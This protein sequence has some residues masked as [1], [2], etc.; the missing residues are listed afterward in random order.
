MTMRQRAA[1]IALAAPYVARRPAA[2]LAIRRPPVPT[3][4][5]CAEQE[6]PQWRRQGLFY[7]TPRAPKDVPLVVDLFI[8]GSEMELLEARMYELQESV[9]WFVVG[10]SRETHRGDTVPFGWLQHA[11]DN[12]GRFAEH[13]DRML[14]VDVTACQQASPETRATNRPD[15]PAPKEANFDTQ[16][17]QRQCLWKLGVPA[18]R[19]R[20]G[21][22]ELPG[23]T[24]FVFTDLDEI[25]DRALV[26]HLKRCATKDGILPAHLHMR[27]QG[28][29][30]RVPCSDGIRSYTGRAEIARWDGIRSSGGTLH[31]FGDG[32]SQQKRKRNI[33]QAGVHMTWFGS[34]AMVD[35]KG[36]THAEGGYWPPLWWSSSGVDTVSGYCG[37]NTSTS[38]AR[39]AGL[40]ARPRSTVRF[41]EQRGERDLPPIVDVERAKRQLYACGLPWVAVENPARYAFWWGNGTAADLERLAD[42]S[43][44]DWSRNREYVR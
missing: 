7:G 23:N 40:N 6:G 18:L 1:L 33:P 9:D 27:K 13:L 8:V 5:D 10:V 42:R 38:A 30:F 41:W 34:M 14:V 28:H 39:Q 3:K 32:T 21:L 26:L 22:E 31:R 2:P 15:R 44:L 11:R 37:A 43:I 4:L 20:I 29:N 19:R 16:R 12:H 36:F 35:F 24:I 17:R 25:P